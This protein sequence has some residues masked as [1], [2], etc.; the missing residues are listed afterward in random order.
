[1]LSEKCPTPMK[2]IGVQDMFASSGD[3]ELLYA[4]HSMTVADIV[5]AAKRLIDAKA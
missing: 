2:R 5:T 3:P 1:V 4:E